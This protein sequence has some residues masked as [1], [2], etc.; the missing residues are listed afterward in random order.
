MGRILQLLNQL[1]TIFNF[2]AYAIVAGTYFYLR[3]RTPSSTAHAYTYL[4]LAW[5]FIAATPLPGIIR[6]TFPPTMPHVHI[7]SLKLSM[8]ACAFAFAWQYMFIGNFYVN[9]LLRYLFYL[10]GWLVTVP[11]NFLS[12][13]RNN[14]TIE[15]SSAG[16]EVIL[17][18]F[19]FF[20]TLLAWS[21][22]LGSFAITMIY[23][24]RHLVDK[25]IKAK[26]IKVFS[27]YIVFWL[28][29]LGESFG[30]L[31]SLMGGIGILLIR[32]ILGI[33]AFITIII[34]SGKRI[35]R[36]ALSNLFCPFQ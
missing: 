33:M 15:S 22:L 23:V 34:W 4:L 17:S 7:W 32:L 24:H 27:T 31:F 26:V 35:F 18:P 13:L 25:R 5:I 1:I 19:A 11:L 28:L 14:F 8:V 21:L 6:N 20:T 2:S 29:Y 30:L 10:L 12:I 3:K 16:I 36:D 9:P